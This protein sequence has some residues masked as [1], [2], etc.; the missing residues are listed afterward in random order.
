[1]GQNASPIDSL[2]RWID[3]PIHVY[4]EEHGYQCLSLTCHSFLCQPFSTND[5]K[6]CSRALPYGRFF[7]HRIPLSLSTNRAVFLVLIE[8]PSQS[9]VKY[10]SCKP[11]FTHFPRKHVCDAWLCH[12]HFNKI[13]DQIRHH[14]IWLVFLRSVSSKLRCLQA[15]KRHLRKIICPVLGSF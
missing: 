12:F 9:F 4:L 10:L 8:I 7:P 5:R 2:Y 3:P 6:C 1:M 11:W 14:K 15:M 13:I